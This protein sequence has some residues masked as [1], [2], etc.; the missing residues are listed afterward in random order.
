MLEA[1][2]DL[3]P[4]RIAE[5]V[6]ALLAQPFSPKPFGSVVDPTGVGPEIKLDNT[7]LHDVTCTV[8]T[9]FGIAKMLRLNA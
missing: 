3:R 8:L 7:A 2:D 1:T 6:K 4:E 9:N 5:A